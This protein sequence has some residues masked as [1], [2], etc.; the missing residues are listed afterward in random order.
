MTGQPPDPPPRQQIN[1]DGG[2]GFIGGR[3]HHHYGD[4]LAGTASEAS[5]NATSQGVI[6]GTPITSWE[7]GHLGVHA[8][9]TVHEETTLT[10]YL[11]R[12]HDRQLREVLER[13][14]GPTLL[15]V[16]GNSCAGKTRSLYEAVL[17]VLPDWQVTAPHT[18]S[19]LAQTLTVGLPAQT[20]VWLDE[21]QDR[22]LATP[23]GITAAKA[24]TELL[25]AADV[26]PIMFAGTLWPSNHAVMRARP[27]PAAAASGAGA[28]PDLLTRAHIV[29]V[30]DTFT[31]T[32]LQGQ[33]AVD[34]PRIQ[35]AMDTAA[36]TQHPEHGRKI[37][38]VLAG[39]TQLVHR[40]HPPEGTHPADEFSPAAK[41][42]LHAAGDLRRIGMLNPL[43]RWVLD[44]ATPDYLHSPDRRPAGHWLPVAL[45]QTTRAARHD[46]PLTGTHTH[47][48]HHSG[49]PALTP[50][51]ITVDDSGP[52]EAYALHDYLHQEH[53]RI[54]RFS[55]VKP[56]VW[57]HLL[58]HADDLPNVL[59]IVNAAIHRGLL[60][61]AIALL[62]G[63]SAQTQQRRENRL[64]LALAHRGNDEDLAELREMTLRGDRLAAR[65]L[66]Q[67]LARRGSDQDI[68]EL[69]LLSEDHPRTQA[70]LE[71]ALARRGTPEDLTA[72]REFAQA[73]SG[74][75][76]F[77][78]SPRRSRQ[79]PDQ[80]QLNIL[81]SLAERG[82]QKAAHRLAQA[83]ARRATE[84]DVEELRGLAV[85][86]VGGLVLLRVLR[87][88]Q[89][90]CHIVEL[91][92]WGN[93]VKRN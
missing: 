13:A 89:P 25:N 41:A 19:D 55:H 35:Q 81:R 69:R 77:L 86:G 17:E 10:P 84:R 85:S 79:S 43:P 11:A 82:E 36:Y 59:Q 56:S 76:R 5:R 63:E 42:L 74:H 65:K 4:Y 37:T 29:T 27:D 2:T 28:I 58:E 61:I 32:D 54:H 72:L 7:P 46:D 83:L 45:D 78:L 52:Q 23:S 53:L 22:L 91:D 3:H 66:A 62:R 68:T 64:A 9:I 70:S 26:G 92:N 80:G 1:K 15:L 24:I 44:G 51:W 14:D 16:V 34:D 40:L 87:A 71:S 18:D 57:Q 33:A 6:V 21:L 20:V 39:G 49:V 73:G 75:A 8:S 48:I 60:S 30:P 31:D 67:T 38:Q 90:D 47:D 12:A 93:A 50:C 88:R